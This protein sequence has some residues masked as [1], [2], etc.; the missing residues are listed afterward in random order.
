M[1]TRPVSTRFANVINIAQVPHRSPFRYPGGKTWLVPKIRQWLTSL[2]PKPRELAEPFAGGATVGLSALFEN[3]VDKLVL[4][5]KDEDV[6]SVWD[7]LIYGEG[8]RLGDEIVQ[9][10]FSHNAVVS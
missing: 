4:V 1:A 2:T 3:L 7:V 5:E 8:K 6:A 10:E 9:F